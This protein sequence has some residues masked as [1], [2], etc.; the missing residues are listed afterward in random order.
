MTEF[1][2]EP[3]ARDGAAR[4]GRLRG[5]L[6]HAV[7]LAL[8][9]IVPRTGYRADQDQPEQISPTSLRHRQPLYSVSV[10]NLTNDSP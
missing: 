5:A 3:L 9:V 1:C 4:T 2:F 8:V 7:T 10:A 6:I